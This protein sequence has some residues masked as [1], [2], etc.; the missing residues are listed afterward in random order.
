MQASVCVVGGGPAGMMTG[1]L[2]ARAGIDVVVME[3]YPDF[4]RDFRGDTIHPSTL[5]LMDELGFLAGFLAQPHAE[6]TT[7]GARFGTKAYPI[8][9]FSRLR[10]R[11]RFLG[12]M[13][14]WDFLTFVAGQAKR[15]PGFRLLMRTEATGVLREGG[16]VVGVSATT[17]GG[18]LEI[19][20]PLT[21]ACDGRHSTVRDALGLRPVERGAP[22]DVLWFRVS[23]RAD[24]PADG[25]GVFAPGVM[26]VLINRGDYFQCG[27]VIPKGGIDATRARGIDAFRARVAALAPY[28]TDRVAEV[29][30]FDDVHLLTVAVN[31]LPVWSGAGYLC[32]GDAAHAMSPVGG[33]GVNLAIQDA[34]ATANLLAEPL[35]RGPVSDRMLRRVQRRREFPVRVT[36]ALQIAIQDRFLAKL[37]HESGTPRAP[38]PVRILAAIPPLRVVPAY[39]I[40][41]GVRPEHVRSP[42]VRLSPS[43]G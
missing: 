24:D 40:G 39:V 41:V 19:R 14:Q 25:L 23:R 43:V 3:K 17:P 22:I 6:L 11:C 1:L 4:F 10:A 38:L 28:L 15:Y 34:V 9:D 5:Q 42:A 20:A 31:R 8:G 21:I 33:V 16:R 12:I 30:S 35:R 2:L 32:I 27:M 18:P 36:Q 7:V 29:K 26:M 37:L 13:P